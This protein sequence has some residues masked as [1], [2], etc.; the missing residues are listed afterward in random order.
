MA[1]RIVGQREVAPVVVIGEFDGFHVGHRLLVQAGAAVAERERRSL[2]AVVMDDRRIE[3]V[4]DMV[5]DRCRNVLAAGAD[6]VHVLSVDTADVVEGA[7]VAAEIV[8]RLRPAIVVIACRPGDVQETRYPAMRDALACERIEVVEVGRRYDSSGRAITSARVRD[9]VRSGDI[10]TV[11]EYLDRP[12]MLHGE[13]V[14]GGALGRTIGFPTANL[15]AAAGRVIPANG[16]YAAT[17]EL[18]DGRTFCSAVN[19]GVRPTLG[20]DGAVVI[21]AHLADFDEDIYGQHIKI[22]FTARLRAEQ[23]FAS[24]DDLVAQLDRDV[25]CARSLCS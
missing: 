15:A 11:G 18:P 19:I 2:L 25:S 9:A 12:F 21:E 3:H 10:G 8:D 17:V 20:D 1:S 14:H 24:L 7:S 22:R 5:D 13:V 4:V 23:R 6:A 16:V